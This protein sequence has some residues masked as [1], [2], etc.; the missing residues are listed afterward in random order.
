M[1][2]SSDLNIEQWLKQILYYIK[3]KTSI[4]YNKLFVLTT[5]RYPDLM[6]MNVYS[7]ESLSYS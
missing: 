2:H 3:K 1:K 4:L 5:F 7:V 6:M